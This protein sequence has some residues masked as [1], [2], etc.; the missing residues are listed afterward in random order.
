MRSLLTITAAAAVVLS[1]VAGVAAQ[2]DPNTPL[3]PPAGQIYFGAWYERWEG[4]LARNVNERIRGIPGAGLSFFQTDIDISMNKTTQQT[5]LNIT[6]GFLQQLEDTNTDAFAYLT[7]YPFND[8]EGVT[9]AQLDELGDRLLRIIQR[10]RKIFLRLYPEMNGSW[11]IYGQKPRAF[12]AAWRRAF[13]VLNAKI[14]PQ[15]RNMIAYLW[16]PNSGNGYPYYNQTFS[17]NPTAI[18]EDRIE[19]DT[20]GDKVLNLED[21]PYSP[22]YPGDE[23]VDWVGLSIYHYGSEYPWR[24]NVVPEPNKFEGKMQGRF[25]REWGI[26]PFYDMFSGPSGM[27]GVTAG[28]KPFI[29]AEGGATWHYAY[30]A[31]GFARNWTGTPDI[32]SV[33]RVDIKR[34]WWRQFLSRDF[35]QRYPNFRA[36]CTFEF[37]K[38]EEYTFRDFSNFGAPPQD[39][40]GQ[41]DTSIVVAAF[42]EDAQTMDF[43]R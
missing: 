35:L 5:Y 26:F 14:G 6:D 32:T 10:G 38:D 2:A 33:P 40:A 39:I 3:L 24:Q 22:F 37:F 43:V 20:N 30:T 11:F 42:V 23:Y 8:F 28:N 31:K 17:V 27:P 9:D 25:N 7:I 12:I 21:D 1:S 36:A 41:E 18:P 15:N 16:A 29:L 4:D 19:I 34:G 13:N